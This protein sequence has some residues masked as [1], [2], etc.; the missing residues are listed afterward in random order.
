MPDYLPDPDHPGQH[1]D[2]IELVRRYPDRPPPVN[3]EGLLRRDLW[4]RQEALLILCGLAPHNVV[5]SGLPI[6]TIGGGIVYLDG[7]ASAQLDALGL[8]HPR[9]LVHPLPLGVAPQGLELRQ[10]ILR[11]RML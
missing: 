6:G 4:T 3:V 7:I 9:A 5:H 11:T 1:I 8:Q 2:I 10:P